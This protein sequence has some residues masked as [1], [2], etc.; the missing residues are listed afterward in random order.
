MALA[1]RGL[2]WSVPLVDRDVA[3]A[4]G[5]EWLPVPAGVAFAEP[6][7]GLL[8]HQVQFAGAKHSMTNTPPGPSTR[9][10]LPKH[11]AC[12]AWLSRRPALPP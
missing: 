10:T 7:P 4:A 3:V 12:Q 11:A 5:I 6:Q 1:G 2:A 8:G 9:A